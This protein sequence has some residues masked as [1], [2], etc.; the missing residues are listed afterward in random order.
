MQ[1]CI[2]LNDPS[3][4]KY[5]KFAVAPVHTASL[6]YQFSLIEGGEF[7]AYQRYGWIERSKFCLLAIVGKEDEENGGGRNEERNGEEDGDSGDE[8]GKGKGQTTGGEGQGAGREEGGAGEG[9]GGGVGAERQQQKEEDKRQ[10]DGRLSQEKNNHEKKEHDDEG[11]VGQKSLQEKKV[12]PTHS[13]GICEATIYYGQ[14]FYERADKMRFAA[15]KDLN[16]LVQFIKKEYHKLEISGQAFSFKF[17]PS[18]GCLELVFGPQDEPI[19][20]WTVSP[21]IEP[22]QIKERE[23]NKFGSEINNTIPPSCLVSIYADSSRPD[24]VHVLKYAIPLKGL[25]EPMKIKI[26][27]SLKKL[28]AYSV[29]TKDGPNPQNDIKKH[30]NDLKHFLSTS[31]AMFRDIA[32]GCK[33]ERVIK[34][35]N[36]SRTSVPMQAEDFF[37]FVIVVCNTL[38]DISPKC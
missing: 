20:G 5:L 9:A 16:A 18:F 12:V 32:N 27:R 11:R 2:D 10:V 38:I 13:T 14:V 33:E 3:L 17:H 6:P 15:A 22:C 31:E 28:L 34:V 8:G 29:G 37:N 35:N 23:M 30:L 19:T 24:T 25:L 21:E 4:S 36:I 1:H 26:N 7:P